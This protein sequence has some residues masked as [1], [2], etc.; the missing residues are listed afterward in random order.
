[1][2]PRR[3]ARVAMAAAATGDPRRTSFA[4]ALAR[5]RR[6]AFGRRRVRRVRARDPRERVGA[7]REDALELCLLERVQDLADARPGSVTQ[8][9][10]V[11]AAEQPRRTH[12]LLR[13]RGELGATELVVLEIA[14]RGGRVDAGE[15]EE[16][17]DA[18]LAQEALQRRGAHARGVHQAQVVADEI[19]DP[20][21]HRA[22]ALQP[23]ADRDRHLGATLGMAVERDAITLRRDAM[24]DAHGP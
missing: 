7:R 20:L 2:Q 4:A 23:L 12:L 18:V 10:E 8:R 1:M 15:L 14:A 6:R 9:D 19:R 16:L 11:V 5:W 17:F 24:S 13:Q 22:A 21:P 3:A